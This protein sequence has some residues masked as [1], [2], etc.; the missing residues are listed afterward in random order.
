MGWILGPTDKDRPVEKP[1][2]RL[3]CPIQSKNKG[4]NV[5][6]RDFSYAA[7]FYLGPGRYEA[8]RGID[9][10]GRLAPAAWASI[11]LISS[12]SGGG[13]QACFMHPPGSI[14]RQIGEPI[15]M[16]F[17]AVGTGPETT[18]N[19]KKRLTKHINV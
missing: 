9:P 17:R 5:L 13:V 18:V 16:G 10:E 4:G 6:E 3:E 7:A 11:V 14:L 12:Q 2:V 19:S 1:E 15:D 8:G